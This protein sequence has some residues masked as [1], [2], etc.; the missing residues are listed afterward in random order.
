MRPRDLFGVGV[1]ILAVWFWTQAAF[2]GYWSAL[3]AFGVVVGN[4]SVSLRQ[5][6]GGVILYGLLGVFLMG[7]ARALVWL[8]YGDDQKAALPADIERD[9]AEPSN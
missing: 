9:A 6:V 3:K 5:D 1:R 8:A 2:W 7:G 4:P